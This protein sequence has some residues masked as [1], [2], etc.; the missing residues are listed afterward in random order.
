MI[1]YYLVKFGVAARID[2]VFALRF[3]SQSDESNQTS[4]CNER[5][6]ESDAV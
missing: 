1:L 5:Q 4:V 3:D 6:D 2:V